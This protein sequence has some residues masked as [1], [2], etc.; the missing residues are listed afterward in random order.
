ML[1]IDYQRFV[2][3]GK[4]PSITNLPQN[5]QLLYACIEI[6]GEAGEISEKVKKIFRDKDGKVSEEDRFFLKKEIGDVLWGLAAISDLLELQLQ[7]VLELN[8]KKCKE[9]IR[10]GTVSGYGDERTIDTVPVYDEEEG[11]IFLKNRKP[12]GFGG[13][14]TTRQQ[15]LRSAAGFYIGT[16]Y[17]D[18][19][20]HWYPY[21]R[22]SE[23]YWGTRHAA[24]TALIERKFTIKL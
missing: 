2:K 17:K 7:D 4:L 3:E 19:D 15:V 18:E 22:D 20:Q 10:T 24:E 8:V 13:C 5:V 21:S 16:L 12:V 1:L 11:V 14:G 9:R 23:E 6:Q